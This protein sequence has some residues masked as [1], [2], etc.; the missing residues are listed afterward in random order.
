[1]T[2]GLVSEKNKDGSLGVLQ[3]EIQFNTGWRDTEK[4][5]NCLEAGIRGKG[6]H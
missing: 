4:R 5:K 6:D 1:M 3:E 2:G